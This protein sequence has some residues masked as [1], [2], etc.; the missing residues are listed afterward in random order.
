MKISGYTKNDMGFM[1]A[2]SIFSHL[3]TV[4]D[5]TIFTICDL[6]DFVVTLAVTHERKFKK[7]QSR[8]NQGLRNNFRSLR[9]A[10]NMI[11]YH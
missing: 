11:T 6:K 1:L 9:F 2:V 7:G 8:S 3:L 10:K 4:G 5:R